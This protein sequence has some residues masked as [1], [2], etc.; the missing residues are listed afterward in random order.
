MIR[1]IRIFGDPVLH[2]LAA[3]VTDFDDNLRQ[4][5]ADMFETMDEAPGVGLAAPQV[6]VSLRVFVYSYPDDDDNP[7]RGVIINPTL[8]HTPPSPKANRLR[9]WKARGACRFR[10]SALALDAASK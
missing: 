7:R 8:S 2:R 9:N 10:V 4:L 3:E 1:P 6:G 5:V